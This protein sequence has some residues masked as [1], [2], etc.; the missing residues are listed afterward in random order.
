MKYKTWLEEHSKKHKNIV[1]KLLKK[2]LDEDA[3]IDYF[4]YENMVQN[5]ND[6]CPLYKK[7][8]KCHEIEKLNCYLCACP[9]FRFND[10]G[11]Y[12][13]DQ[14]LVLST[15]SINMGEK[16]SHGNK[17]HHSCSKCTVPHRKSFIKKVFDYDHKNIMAKSEIKGMA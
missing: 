5:E 2:G 15:C 1:D 6:F 4:C 16:I 3:I 9:Y 10:D 13:Q 7:N 11:L 12:T 14:H 17:T 8:K